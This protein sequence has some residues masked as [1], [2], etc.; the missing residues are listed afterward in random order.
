MIFLKDQNFLKKNICPKEM[1]AVTFD[2]LPMEYL[3]L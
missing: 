1:H 2:K 3:P